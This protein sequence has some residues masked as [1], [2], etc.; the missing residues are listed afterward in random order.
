MLALIAHTDE[1]S[2]LIV[3][4]IEDSKPVMVLRA[5]ADKLRGLRWI[6][7]DHL[8]ITTS[9]T[10]KFSGIYSPRTE[11]TEVVDINVKAGTRMNL[12][13][14]ARGA[15][16][17]TVG[18]PQ[19]RYLGGKPIAFVQACYFVNEDC[20]ISLFRVDMSTGETALA[21]IGER[22]TDG[23]LVGRGGGAIAQSLYDATGGK[24]SLRVFHGGGW[25]IADEAA[26][27][28]GNNGVLGLGR[29]GRSVMIGAVKDGKDVLLELSSTTDHWGDPL[30]VP[31]EDNLIFDPADE[32]LIGDHA[33]S[34]DNEQYV[35]FDAADQAIWDAM[36][37]AFP[38]ARVTL[39]AHDGP[40]HQKLL[41]RVDS[42]QRQRQRYDIVDRT[43]PPTR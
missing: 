10:G 28:Y 25:Q 31:D 21:S 43:R 37:S 29:D 22:D 1:A 4:R 7:A 41:V 38:G 9:F 17:A 11:W 12:L 14:G 16:P 5:D 26:L 27:A 39:V 8:L 33:L 15:L 2:G 34:G 24:W 13:G 32:R 20:R 3:K 30:P 40:D 23:W 42:T 36:R 35:F 19:I 18:E 6:G